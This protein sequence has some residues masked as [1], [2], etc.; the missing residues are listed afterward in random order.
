M[1]IILMNHHEALILDDGEKIVTVEPETDGILTVNGKTYEVSCGSS[2]PVFNEAESPTARA[3]FTTARGIRYAVLA[4]RIEK[5]GL[6]SRLDPYTYAVKL[7][8][9]IDRLEKELEAARAEHRELSGSIRYDALG[10]MNFNA[11][12]K[13]DVRK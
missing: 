10:F 4:P 8:L 11:D 12:D 5:K 13:E 7:R 6:V 3:C 9:M 2:A 1:K